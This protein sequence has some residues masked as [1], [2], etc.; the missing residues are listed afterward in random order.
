MDRRLAAM[1]AFQL[2]CSGGPGA[3]SRGLI[4]GR[5][6]ARSAL[7]KRMAAGRTLATRRGWVEGCENVLAARP[8]R[9][10]R[11]LALP[12]C[13]GVARRAVLRHLLGCGSSRRV[14][15]VFTQGVVG[16]HF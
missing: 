15:V 4:A 7:A 16:G 2:P 11:R 14:P 6:R 3:G 1:M 8:V 5:S 9:A 13:D 12:V 10:R